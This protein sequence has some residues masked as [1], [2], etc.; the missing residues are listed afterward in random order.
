[1]GELNELCGFKINW[2]KSIAFPHLKIKHLE[3]VTEGGLPFI[4]AIT[5]EQLRINLM[6]QL[7]DFY[8]TE[9]EKLILRGIFFESMR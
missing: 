4:M 6:R 7:Q 1:M 8:S 9:K 2:Q 3:N 5:L